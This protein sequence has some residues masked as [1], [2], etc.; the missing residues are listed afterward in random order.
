MRVSDNRYEE[1]LRKHNL[2]I[3]MIG[4]GARTRTITRWTGLNRQ[5]VQR[6]ARRYQ[7]SE[8]GDH[9][10]R[11]ISPFQSAYFTNSET[12][13]A[14]SLAL[15]FI[16]SELQV[17]PSGSLPDQPRSLPELARG[18]RLVMAYEWYRA[19]VP[20]AQISLERA[21]LF[22]TELMDGRTLGL[23]RCKSC[24]DPMVVDRR[25]PTLSEPCPFCRADRRAMACGYDTLSDSAT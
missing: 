20:E 6:L 5:R 2:A 18:E 17:I 19:L 23:R 14:E 13:E 1:D 21:V 4:H 9:R 10:R 3:W 24:A 8:P 16:A 25:Q 12:L 22:I 11:G 7:D 15:A